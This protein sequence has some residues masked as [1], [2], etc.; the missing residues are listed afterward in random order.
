MWVGAH[1]FDVRR[2]DVEGNLRCAE[3]GIRRAAGA[4]VELLVL[5]EVWPTSFPGPETDLEAALEGTERCRERVR[6]LARELGVLVCG[7]SLARPE[8]SGLPTNRLE[9]TDG[10]RC[11]LSYDKV[12]LF[13]PTAE[14]E[15]TA[16]GSAPPPTA[17]TRLGRLGGLICYDLRFPEL[18]R[19]PFRDGA[20][21]VC[22]PAQWPSTRARHFETL[23]VALAVLGQCF[24]V[25]ANRTGRDVIGRR[26]LELDFPGNSL[27]VDP[28]GRVLARGRGEEGLVAAEIDLGL[29]REMR[30]QVP[31]ERDARPDLYDAWSD[32][33][34]AAP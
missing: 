17:D 10:E 27:V 19:V 33:T 20:E 4:G 3:E 28:H 23:A 11:L 32:R 13:S 9:L 18:T 5:P 34:R 22:V 26:E 24:V 2:G 1:Q 31:V 7:S 12:H 14:G 8:G 25:A 6:E 30:R 29:A 15:S 16:P 21:L